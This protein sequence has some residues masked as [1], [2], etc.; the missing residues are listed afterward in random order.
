MKITITIKDEND[1]NTAMSKCDIIDFKKWLSSVL[2]QMYV[3]GKTKIAEE[4]AQPTIIE[5]MVKVE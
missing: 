4:T 2:N 5:S 3:N 1:F